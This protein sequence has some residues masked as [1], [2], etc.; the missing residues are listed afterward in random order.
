MSPCPRLPGF[1]P[2]SQLRPSLDT[3]PEL[4]ALLATEEAIHA[5]RRNLAEAIRHRHRLQPEVRALLRLADDLWR[6]ALEESQAL[7]AEVAEAERRLLEA[8]RNGR[9]P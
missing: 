8:T 2:E 6:R 9:V 4:Q 1:R 5:A 3:P 7:A